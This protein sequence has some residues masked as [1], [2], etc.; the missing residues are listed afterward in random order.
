MRRRTSRAALL[1]GR[2]SR[3]L[4]DLSAVPL[5]AFHGAGASGGRAL[6]RWL[7]SVAPE[8]LV[9]TARR[10]LAEQPR[11]FTTAFITGGEEHYH[12]E[13]FSPGG[14]RIHFCGHG[15]LIAGWYAL[16][17]HESAPVTLM[18]QSGYRCWELKPC[19]L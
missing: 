15:S 3:S 16:T 11:D 5:H 9:A 4:T 2:V 10:E 12:A 14:H 6:V 13:F 18:F 1:S 8:D 7:P 17:H 19:E